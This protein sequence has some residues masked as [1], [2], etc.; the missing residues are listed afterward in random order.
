MVIVSCANANA[1]SSSAISCCSHVDSIDTNVSAEDIAAFRPAFSILIILNAYDFSQFI[2]FIVC[3]VVVFSPLQCIYIY[4]FQF[5]LLF[6]FLYDYLM[7]NANLSYHTRPLLFV[8]LDARAWEC[9]CF[10]VVHD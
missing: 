10:A 1:R 8:V 4:F 7:Q 2:I 3:V 6:S 5:S 9:Q